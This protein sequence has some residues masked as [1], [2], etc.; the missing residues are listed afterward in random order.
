MSTTKLDHLESKLNA[1]IATLDGGGDLS[2]D[3]GRE[4][5]Q[6]LDCKE[7]NGACREGLRAVIAALG[8]DTSEAVS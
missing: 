2:A 6:Y 7:L 3:A 4:L 1:M 8:I 5:T